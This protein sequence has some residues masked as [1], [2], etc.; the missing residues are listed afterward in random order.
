M[1]GIKRGEQPVGIEEEAACVHSPCGFISLADSRRICTYSVSHVECGCIIDLVGIDK[2]HSKAQLMSGIETSVRRENQIHIKFTLVL[3]CD[4]TVLHIAAERCAVGI[5]ETVVGSDF[6][7][8][9]KSHLHITAWLHVQHMQIGT[10]LPAARMIMVQHERDIMQKSLIH[11]AQAPV[12]G[13]AV[14]DIH[15]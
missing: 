4:E 3:Y 5:E 10:Q 2:F 11:I 1:Y 15:I 9:G 8:S 7:D 14:A 12:S 13:P 6:I